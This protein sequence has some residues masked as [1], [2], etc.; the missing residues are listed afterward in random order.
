MISQS[1]EFKF[2]DR[3]YKET[4]LLVPGWGLDYRTFAALETSCNYLV[5]LKVW[6]ADFIKKLDEALQRMALERISILGHSM[7]GFLATDFA[8]EYPDKV[9][10]LILVGIRKRYSERDI[11]P[12]RENIGKNRAG[13]MYKMY[14]MS[15]SAAEKEALSLFK[16]TLLKTYIKEMDET[17]LYAGLDY[18]SAATIQAQSLKGANVRFVHGEADVVAPISEAS[19]IAA[20]LP[21]SRFDRVKDGGHMLVLRKDFNSI[22]NEG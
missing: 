19:A 15:F 1:S 3:G 20:E 7:G 16:S 22:L 9:A 18:L 10:S 14:D 2:V 13:F 6:P 8:A 17:L 5:A 12:V 4:L 11:E 21:G